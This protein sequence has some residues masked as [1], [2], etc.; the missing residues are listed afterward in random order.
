MHVRPHPAGALRHFSQRLDALRDE[1]AAQLAGPPGDAERRAEATLAL[2]RLMFGHFLGGGAAPVEQPGS[3]PRE[4]IA[5]AQ[6]LFDSYAW[7]L[8]ASDAADA[9]T[10]DAL[11]A[12]FE[13]SLERKQSGA[14]YTQADVADYIA[15]ATIVPWVLEEAARLRPQ[16]FGAGGAVWR[17]LSA[18][19]ERYIHPDMRHG[20][21][22]PRA[23][24]LVERVAGAAAEVDEATRRVS[25]PVRD[26]MEALT[27][28]VRG[29][30][31]ERIDAEDLLVR[32]PTLDEVFLRLTE[33]EGVAA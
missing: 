9:I 20:A 26:R 18:R 21:D 14:Y 30:Q 32:R 8:R 6:E 7:S 5:R 27:A 1:V 13:R 25:A 3:L 33:R 23:A 2:C 22:L 17:L 28:L 11:G 15:R 4:A 29:L 31:H 24:A 16:T 19:P 10:P 12:F